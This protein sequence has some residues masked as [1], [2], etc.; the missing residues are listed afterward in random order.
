MSDASALA[1]RKQL[2]RI[3]FDTLPYIVA[4]AREWAGRRF[5]EF[6]TA[7]IRNKNTRLAY[8]RVGRHQW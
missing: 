1:S 8:A 4:A 6:I 2:G 3:G 7:N 5:I